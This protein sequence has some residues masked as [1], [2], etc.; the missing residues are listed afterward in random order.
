MYAMVL[1]NA[2]MLQEIS[3]LKTING[4]PA[5]DHLADLVSGRVKI[6]ELR[7]PMFSAAE[8]RAIAEKSLPC[9][10]QNNSTRFVPA[11]VKGYGHCPAKTVHRC[12]PN[13]I[14]IYEFSL[15]FSG[16]DG[17]VGP[18]RRGVRWP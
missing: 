14:Y 13:P 6:E 16:K 17:Q 3:S 10:L 15:E 8:L 4:R 11:G 1:R 7:S 2:P 12:D 18:P 9:L 5:K